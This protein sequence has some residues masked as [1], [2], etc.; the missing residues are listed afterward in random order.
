MTAWYTETLHFTSTGVCV[1]SF[2]MGESLQNCPYLAVWCLDP[3]TQMVS[4]HVLL[5]VVVHD[6]SLSRGMP[7]TCPPPEQYFHPTTYNFGRCQQKFSNNLQN[8]SPVVI[9]YF[10]VRF[11]C[12][13]ICLYSHAVVWSYWRFTKRV[14]MNMFC[15]FHVADAT[16]LLNSGIVHSTCSGY[17]KEVGYLRFHAGIKCHGINEVY[18]VSTDLCQS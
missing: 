12:T 2:R 1:L 15:S 11:Q 18:Q 9:L 4:P 14:L 16:C 5:D 17:Q 6:R 8:Q 3:V 13:V 7:L 10:A